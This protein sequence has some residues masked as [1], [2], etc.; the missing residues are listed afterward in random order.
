MSGGGYS[1]IP[2]VGLA[3]RTKSQSHAQ[4]I[5]Q[6]M[7]KETESSARQQQREAGDN[8]IPPSFHPICWCA[9]QQRHLHWRAGKTLAPLQVAAKDENTAPALGARSSPAFLHDPPGGHKV[10][11][12]QLSLRSSL[13]AHP[14]RVVFFLVVL[15]V[16][17]AWVN[18]CF[19]LFSCA[20]VRGCCTKWI[21]I[22]HSS[23]T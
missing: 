8:K 10:L 13:D 18:R 16:F 1:S 9:P 19:L 21:C 12:Q 23:K 11:I 3:V 2:A 4:Q 20:P 17:R 15:F 6:K 14:K 7:M 22:P 5:Q